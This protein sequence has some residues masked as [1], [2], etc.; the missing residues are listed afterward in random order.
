[1]EFCYEDGGCSNTTIESGIKELLLLTI[2][3]GML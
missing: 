1:M 3:K 2:S